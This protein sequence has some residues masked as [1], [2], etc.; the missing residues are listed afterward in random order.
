[1]N[2]QGQ[3]Y[4]T[5]KLLI[6]AIVAMAIL[7]I[8]IPIIMN[9]IGLIK[10]SPQDEAKS[11]LSD[12]VGAP[13]ALK[14]TKEVVFE[15]DSVL[16]ASALAERL[17]LAKDQI[18]MSTG[19]FEEDAFVTLK[20]NGFD[21]YLDSKES[22]ENGMVEFEYLS[23]GSYEIGAVD[24]DKK[25]EAT[26]SISLLKD[27]T[28][29]V[30]LI[31]ITGEGRINFDFL[32]PE[33]DDA[34]VNYKFIADENIF[35]EGITTRG[36]FRS[37]LIKKGTKVKMITDTLGQ[38][39]HESIEY[40]ISRDS[41]TKD[42]F[43]RDENDI[44]N[45]KEV[46]M[47]FM[48]VYD[49]N[50]IYGSTSNSNRIEPGEEYYIYFDLILNNENNETVLA[51][52]A[53][54][55][56]S[57]KGITIED[58]YSING[59]Q[60]VLVSA[61]G[62]DIIDKQN[63][64][65]IVDGAALQANAILPEQQGKKS[66]PII[67]KIKVD[68]NAPL[69][70]ISN[71]KFNAFHGNV[72][73]LNYNKEIVIGEEICL[74]NDCPVFLFNNYLKWGERDYVVLEDDVSNQLLIG[75]E[76]KIKTTVKNLS[77]ETIGASKL[78][79]SV[80]KE[81]IAYLTIED[82]NTKS[83]DIVLNELDSSSEKE[84]NMNPLK[85]TS[86]LGLFQKVTKEQNGIDTIRNYEGNNNSLRFKIAEKEE[87]DIS[88]SPQAMDEGSK[89]FFFVI[90]TK[91]KSK[92]TG[93]PAHWYIEK[94][95]VRLGQGYEGQTDENGIQ[96]LSI[97]GSDFKEGDEVIFTAYD[98]TGAIDG[99]DTLTITNPFSEVEPEVPECIKIKLSGVNVTNTDIPTEKLIKNQKT[100]IDIIS[101]CSSERRILLHSDLLVSN[102]QFYVQPNTTETIDI[103]AKPRDDILGVYPIQI[104]SIDDSTYKTLKIIDI[105]ISDPNS[106]FDLSEAIFDFR[107]ASELTTT[108]ENKNFEGR[109]DNYHPQVLL[110]TESVSLQFNKPGLPEIYDYNLAVRATAIESIT[111][112]GVKSE[113]VYSH[114]EE[115]YWG[116]DHTTARRVAATAVIDSDVASRLCAS[117]TP[118]YEETPKPE[119]E[120][121]Q[122]IRSAI[123]SYDPSE[124]L[125]QT[126]NST[127]ITNGELSSKK[128]KKLS[129]T[130]YSGGYIQN[131]Y[132]PSTDLEGEFTVNALPLTY[133]PLG[134]ATST[135]KQVGSAP[136]THKSSGGGIVEYFWHPKYSDSFG[137]TTA[138]PIDSSEVSIWA[139]Q[140]SGERCTK[141]NA[142][143]PYWRLT[144]YGNL[145]DV[146]K[147]IWKI[148]GG[149]ETRK[150]LL[151]GRVS[152]STF[153]SDSTTYDSNTQ[154]IA[155][156]IHE[157]ALEKSPVY[158]KNFVNGDCPW[159]TIGNCDDG[160]IK[161]QVDYLQA[162]EFLA[163]I[164][165]STIVPINIK[166]IEDT[167]YNI[168]SYRDFTLAPRWTNVDTQFTDYESGDT[169]TR[170]NQLYTVGCI[171]PNGIVSW[172]H[173]AS[174]GHQYADSCNAMPIRPLIMDANDPLVEYDSS[175]NIRYWVHPE[176][177]P[178]DLNVYLYQGNLYAEYVGVS[179]I[180]GKNINVS[181]T[182]NNLIGREY[183][184]VT[185]K[186]WVKDSTDKFVKAH[187][188]FQVKLIGN[189][190]N[191]YAS[192]G[193][194]GVTGTEFTPK[195]LFNWEWQ[196][197]SSQQCDEENYTYTYC[198]GVQFNIS[199]FK[200]LNEIEDM[201]LKNNLSGVP[202]KTAFYAYLI[203]ENYNK[204]LLND[205]LE[206]YNTS[207][208]N[209]GTT[210]SKLKKF[211]EEDKLEFKV[212]YEN[213]TLLPYGGLYRVEIDL[214]RTNENLYSLFNGDSLNATI[215]VHLIP[216]RRAS[217]YNPFYEL[218]FD[219]EVG[220]IRSGYG[221]G[222]TNDLELLEDVTT[223]DASNAMR[224]INFY[225]ST[226]PSVLDDAIV[227]VYDINSNDFVFAPS[228]P[229]PVEITIERDNDRAQLQYTISGLGASNVPAKQWKLK[230]STIGNSK[231]YD[232]ENQDKQTF[233]E[234]KTGTTHKV[235]WE[236]L[237]NGTLGLTT[238]Y[239]TPKDS[240]APLTLTPVDEKTNTLSS[241]SNL[242]NNTSIILKNYDNRG[243]T[244]YDTLNGIFNLIKEEKMAI[245]MSSTNVKI[246]WNPD[247]IAELEEEVESSSGY[248]CG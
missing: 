24:E 1:M 243:I 123:P 54:E 103:T 25:D 98:N 172:E 245:S 196:N 84:I 31:L 41:Q 179:E 215:V 155:A 174:V 6:A 50:P 128:E 119:P 3:A 4:S 159:H 2:Q 225:H 20:I 217:N 247:Y 91:Y 236:K 210:F 195:L 183:A 100:N 40:E 157:N 5:F 57:N 70:S 138:Y 121:P 95:G 90:K 68:Q 214:Q 46:Q 232:F 175:G 134:G 192:D 74:G 231:C 166:P 13:G 62:E 63:N 102:N 222:G 77:D 115:S 221:V 177:I 65:F 71:L 184:I 60:R 59:L 108:I 105:E 203:K 130:T 133:N 165:E 154:F 69:E 153:L 173:A 44:P 82:S 67:L 151:G 30:S 87:I 7:A 17:P 202:E 28:V 208:L 122:R 73:S 244:D 125:P 147:M 188:A 237:M 11:L 224:K 131:L 110:D 181:L 140:L 29:E 180:A 111:Y 66:I 129:F 241:Y 189:T 200:K 186:D 216:I 171:I 233:D 36:S 201:L 18:C 167:V 141:Y 227:L 33:Y 212:D 238:T 78:V 64:Q 76:Y 230:S 96:I 148:T 218:P 86:S 26:K 191:V 109:K 235:S 137:T 144:P 52:F 198:D 213:N 80:P 234:T 219:G 226:D 88:I 204:N 161:I 162:I 49:S 42:V 169:F 205:F 136:T 178:A 220:E 16:A 248:S 9:V 61:V 168:G 124:V 92:Y 194:S 239:F 81:K 106:N 132:N 15:S 89:Q 228:Q 8:L 45:D 146:E 126:G 143:D 51:N 242:M 38:F 197:I 187:Q 149:E 83:F 94:N 160:K 14:H 120:P 135:R 156:G 75:D 79:F 101:E 34:K 164:D 47:F 185:V 58:I 139:E 240:T 39:Y 117:V 55:N 112:S 56:D 223:K 23:N 85:K 190:H 152:E 127:S 199:L 206:Y 158:F 182:K 97:D 209:S 176:D 113:I 193:S 207:F 114:H 12:L 27:Q 170:G 229:T 53:L 142:G 145:N 22:D 93:I 118:E 163:S 116:S 35:A 32:D 211:I 48:Q 37:D 10:A 104:V 72:E 99:T 21:S 150:I 107:N 246:F 19:E 43:V